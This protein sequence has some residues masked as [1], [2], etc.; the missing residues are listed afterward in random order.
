MNI[1]SDPVE[2]AFSFWTALVANCSLIVQT[3]ELSRSWALVNTAMTI[4]VLGNASCKNSAV[5][6][7]QIQ[8]RAKRLLSQV[9]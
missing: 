9:Q 8:S 1:S 4:S 2:L 6:Q 3:G 7:S 5:P